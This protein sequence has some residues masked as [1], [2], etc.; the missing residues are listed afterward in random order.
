MKPM[1]RK[2]KLIQVINSVEFSDYDGKSEVGLS[3]DCQ[4]S[5]VDSESTNNFAEE[6]STKGN[7]S[8]DRS[9]NQSLLSDFS[10]FNVSQKSNIAD[11]TNVPNKKGIVKLEIADKDMR[12]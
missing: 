12:D 4:D 7:F 1:R 6:S 3:L 5:M 10:Q 9:W 11:S 2:N 8:D